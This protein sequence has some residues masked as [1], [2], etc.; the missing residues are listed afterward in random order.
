MMRGVVIMIF[1]LLTRVVV[2]QSPYETNKKQEILLSG[3]GVGSL[4]TAWG[5]VGN[6]SP[7]TEVQLG[8]LDGSNI[9]GI[10]RWAID[11]YSNTAKSWS[12]VMMFGS[13]SLPI[14][15]YFVL[16]DKKEMGKVGLMLFESLSISYGV[17]H[18]VKSVFPRNRP[19][20]Y[21]LN[22]S[23]DDQLNIGARRSFFSGHTSF[24][25]TTSFFAASMINAYS[26]NKA[27]KKA[28]WITA[29][30]APA[31]AGFLRIKAGKHFLTDV[32][33]GYVFGAAVGYFIP[34]LHERK[35]EDGSGIS[36]VPYMSPETTGVYVTI[37]LFSR[38]QQGF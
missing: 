8:A 24:T 3:I 28:A 9:S 16:E 19:F 2:A 36:W 13:L 33:A 1:V 10:D 27:I 11:N 29:F 4:L 20:T 34:K 25:A 35:K 18:I 38:K 26:D 7:L 31:V 30:T 23:L 6:V 37:P 21:N 5:L 22:A 17:T 32:T 15:A 12:D 14:G